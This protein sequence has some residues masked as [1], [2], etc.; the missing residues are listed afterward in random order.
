RAL[1][2]KHNAISVGEIVADDFNQVMGDYTTENRLH[3]AYSFEFLSE[4][5]NFDNVDKVVDNF[6]KTNPHSW[7]CWALSNHDSTRIAS[8]SKQTPK[9]L[10]AKLLSLRGNVCIYQGEE[11]GLYESVLDFTDIRDPFGKR[12]WPEFKG[13]DGCRTPMPWISSDM[14]LGFSKTKPWLPVD[15]GFKDLAV[16]KQLNDNESNLNYFKKLIQQRKRR[17]T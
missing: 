16:D 17:F 2:D 6:F 11:L 15:S 5:F 4:E 12:F 7:P 3:M 1:L 13:R 8:R 10:M 9:E 14:N